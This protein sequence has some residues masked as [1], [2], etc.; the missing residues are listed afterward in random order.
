ML[1]EEIETIIEQIIDKK[2]PAVIN[3]YNPLDVDQFLDTITLKIERILLKQVELEKENEQKTQLINKLENKNKILTIEIENLKAQ[4][5][6]K[7]Q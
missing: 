3:G 2:F 5:K 7:K 4:T 1:K 6:W